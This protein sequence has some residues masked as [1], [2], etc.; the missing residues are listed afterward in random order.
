MSDGT[1]LHKA[2]TENEA[3]ALLGV[4]PR[5]LQAWRQQRKGPQY[6]SYSVRAIRYRLADLLRFQEEHTRGAA[7]VAR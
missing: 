3:A 6:I 1:N 2:L 7:E 4:Q 5:T